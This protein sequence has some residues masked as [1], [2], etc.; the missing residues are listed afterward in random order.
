MD[1]AKGTQKQEEVNS[2]VE[3][4]VKAG[5]NLIMNEILPEECVYAIEPDILAKL[6]SSVIEPDETVIFAIR[7]SKLHNLLAPEIILVTNRKIVMA[8]PSILHYLKIKSMALK[9]SN[10]LQYSKINEIEMNRG[11]MLRS[12][13]IAVAGAQDEVEI[14][15]L[16]QREAELFTK[17]LQKVLEGLGQ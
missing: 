17:F 4:A 9:F 7:Q 12:I 5:A 3:N 8:Q 10:Y 16:G 2:K 1:A 14:Q 13:T 15:G 6:K 11:L